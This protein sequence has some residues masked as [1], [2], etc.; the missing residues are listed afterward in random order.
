MEKSIPEMYGSLVFND[1]VMKEKLP[2]DVYRKL[3]KTSKY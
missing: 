3:H 1:S 2:K